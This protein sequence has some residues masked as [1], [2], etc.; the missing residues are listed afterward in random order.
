MK[1]T[2]VP[3]WTPEFIGYG[4][5]SSVFYVVQYIIGGSLADRDRYRISRFRI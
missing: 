2:N 5:S 1:K 3:L 4:I